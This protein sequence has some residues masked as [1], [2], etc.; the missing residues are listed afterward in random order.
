M[1]L[2]GP[3]ERF[4]DDTQLLAPVHQHCQSHLITQCR[5]RDGYLIHLTHS[6][7]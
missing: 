4:V 5:Y 1:R 6:Q 3:E 2:F 7:S